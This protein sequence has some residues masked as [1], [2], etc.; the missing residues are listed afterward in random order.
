[1][2]SAP[3][4][5]ATSHPHRMNAKVGPMRRRGL[6]DND[7]IP[8]HQPDVELRL[9]ARD[10]LAVVDARARL[11]ALVVAKERH[12]SLVGI[13]GEAAR[14]RDR[15]EEA[16]LAMEVQGPLRLDLAQ[17]EDLVVVDLLDDDGDDGLLDVLRESLGDVVGES[18]G[19]A[20]G[21]LNVP[22]ERESD[23]A[24]GP[25]GHRP[26]KVGLFP[27]GDGELVLDTQHVLLDGAARCG[28]GIPL[29]SNRINGEE[30][31]GD[32]EHE[33]GGALRDRFHGCD[34]PCR[35][36]P[37]IARTSR[38]CCC[39][40]NRAEASTDLPGLVRAVKK[41]N[42]QVRKKTKPLKSSRSRQWV[43][44]IREASNSKEAGC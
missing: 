35:V 1:M 37:P 19:R 8:G 21:G 40:S 15:L 38:Y 34:A 13:R 2:T 6:V 36:D 23:L 39:P 31:A 3:C 33:Y 11:L 22:D 20:T 4:A 25:D 12:I 9:L 30:E 10:H 29:G 24:V 43:G 16:R 14:H 32:E 27:N 44:G 42:E 7:R 26:E 41:G 17:D 18:S 5:G 28:R